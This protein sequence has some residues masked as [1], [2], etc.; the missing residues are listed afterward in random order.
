MYCFVSLSLYIYIYIYVCVCVCVCVRACAR[1]RAHARVH[2]S[3]ASPHFTSKFELI[4]FHFPFYQQIIDSLVDPICS[5]AER[6][7]GMQ[8]VY[9][10]LT[11]PR[12]CIYILYDTG[13]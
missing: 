6:C 2:A 13:I 1:V 7:R 4:F 11:T 12:T 8:E 5:N 3:L 10:L 9:S